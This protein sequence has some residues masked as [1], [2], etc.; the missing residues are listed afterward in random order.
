MNSKNKI[1]QVDGKIYQKSLKFGN[2]SFKIIFKNHKKYSR[3]SKFKN[4]LE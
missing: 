2:S 3:K 1:I 4:S